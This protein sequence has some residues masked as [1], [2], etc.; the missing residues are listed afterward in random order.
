MAILSRAAV[1]LVTALADLGAA[2]ICYSAIAAERG[3]DL[4]KTLM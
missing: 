2:L 4:A 3:I 1:G